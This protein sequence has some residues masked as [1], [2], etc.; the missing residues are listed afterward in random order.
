M[1]LNHDA[2]EQYMFLNCMEATVNQMLGWFFS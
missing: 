1:F 2:V